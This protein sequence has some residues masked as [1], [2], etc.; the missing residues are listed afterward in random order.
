MAA[1]SPRSCFPFFG[2]GLLLKIAFF[3]GCFLLA[4]LVK[5]SLPEASQEVSQEVERE[6]KGHLSLVLLLA[7]AADWEA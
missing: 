5:V 1:V 4:I 7:R 2:E 3:L 6:R